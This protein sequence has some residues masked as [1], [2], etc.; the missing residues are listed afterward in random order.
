MYYT[1]KQKT[2]GENKMWANLKFTT[3]ERKTIEG[4]FNYI[5][6]CHVPDGTLVKLMKQERKG[7]DNR[8]DAIPTLAAKA[9]CVK[10]F[11]EGV[12]KPDALLRDNYYLRPAAVWLIGKGAERRTSAPAINMPALQNA[13]ATWGAAFKRMVDQD[14]IALQAALQAAQKPTAQIVAELA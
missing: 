14:T 2:N 12:E 5:E 13:V 10:W 8:N 6:D 9:L 7:W 1:L 11:L 3:S 4:A